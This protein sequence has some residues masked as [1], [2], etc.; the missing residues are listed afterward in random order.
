[1]LELGSGTGLTGLVVAKTCN[2]SR[3][4]M[5]DGNEKVLALLREN[6]AEN[7]KHGEAIGVVALDWEEVETSLGELEDFPVEVVIAADVV[8]DGTLFQPLCKAIEAVFRLAGSSGCSL[9]LACTVR[10]EDTLEE[11]L[12]QLG[13]FDRCIIV[14]SLDTNFKYL[15]DIFSLSSTLI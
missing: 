8:Y 9:Y 7:C 4:V 14:L 12:R 1:M 10:N 13:K 15:L 5:T 6:V 2:P 11:F 3:L